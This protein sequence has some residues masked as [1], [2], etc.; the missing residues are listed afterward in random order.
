LE[1]VLC[2]AIQHDYISVYACGMAH[3]W[4]RMLIPSLLRFIS[5]QC[6][7]TSLPAALYFA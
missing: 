7:R 2:W 4:L 5:A 3:F 1:H 6:K